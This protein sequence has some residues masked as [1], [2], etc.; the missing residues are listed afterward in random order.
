MLRNGICEAIT[1][2]AFHPRCRFSKSVCEKITPR[3]TTVSA[4][5]F[6]SC[7]MYDEEHKS[8]FEEVRTEELI[9]LR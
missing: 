7:H 9:G 2:C 1:H 5:Q 3:E 6:V 8:E 4:G